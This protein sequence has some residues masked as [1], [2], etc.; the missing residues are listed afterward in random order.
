MS[1]VSVTCVKCEQYMDKSET[2]NGWKYIEAVNTSK[3]RGNI[4]VIGMAG[5]GVGQPGRPPRAPRSKGPQ[6]IKMFVY[7]YKKNCIY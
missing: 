4:Y 1:V 3:Q 5:P 2:I 7:I 6:K